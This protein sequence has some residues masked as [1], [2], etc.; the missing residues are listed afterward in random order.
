MKFQFSIF[1]ILITT[2]C[3]AQNKIPK[4]LEKLKN[5]PFKFFLFLEKLKFS[6]QS[7]RQSLKASRLQ[8]DEMIKIIQD[9]KN[10]IECVMRKSFHPSDSYSKSHTHS[11]GIKSSI[12]DL[13]SFLAE[14]KKR[15]K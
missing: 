9:Q 15:G 4:V 5:F 11:Q 6:L 10:T 13:T 3:F 2:F 7:S 8:N 12:D 1:L 14:R